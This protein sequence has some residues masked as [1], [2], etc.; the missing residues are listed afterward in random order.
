MKPPLPE[1]PAPRPIIEP[2]GLQKS[3]CLWCP[4]LPWSA[5]F[6]EHRPTFCRDGDKVL[7]KE[8]DGHVVRSRAV[9]EEWTEVDVL[10]VGEAP[11][12]DEDKQ[13]IPFVGRS[14]KLLRTGIEEVFDP[15]VTVGIANLVRC[16]PPRNR[17]PNRTEVQ[18]CS[19][20]LIRE[21]A[22]RKP[23]VIVVLGNHSMNFLTGHTGIT[24]FTGK[25]LEA[26]HPEVLGIPVVACLHPAYILRFDHELPKFLDAL[27][28]A[29]DVL[30]GN[31]E[32]KAGVG[33]VLVLDDLDDVRALL[34]AFQ[35]DGDRVAFDT[36]TG[37]LNWW[38]DEFPRLLCFSFANE[39]GTS[40]VVPFDHAESPWCVGG[41]K[42]HEREELIAVLAEFFTSDV[43]KL[44]QNGKFDSKH[45]RAAIGVLPVNVLDTMTT[46][47]TL[48]ERRG[49]HGLDA[50]AYQ[51]TG[52]G[53]YERA[54]SDY[55]NSHAEANPDRGGSYANIPG[56]I[57][58]KYA[59]WDA[60]ATLRVFHG[61]QAEDSYRKNPRFQRLAEMFFPALSEVLTELEW[62]GAQIDPKIV[63]ELDVSY[64][65]EMERISDEI[66]NLDT[67][68]AFV[69]KKELERF[70]PGSSKQLQEILFSPDFYGVAPIT[71]TKGGLDRLRLR[72]QRAVEAWRPAK[73]KKQPA[74]TDVVMEALKRGEYGH[75]STDA[76]AL[77]ELDL[78]GNELASK[79]VEYRAVATL[80]GTFIK[81][82]MLLLDPEGRI[83][84]SFLEHGTVT[85]RL[86]SVDPNLQNIPNKGEG[87]VK[88]AYVSRFGDE[89]VICQADYSQ[90]ELRIG[91][92]I[93]NEPSM[94]RAYCEGV[95]VHTLTAIEIAKLTP[96]AYKA[97]DKNEQKAWRTRAKR[98][99]FGILYQGG[100]AALVKTLK[101]DGVFITFEEA[102]KLIERY[103]EIRPA[104]RAGIDRLQNRV[105]KTGYLESF[106]G[107]R[108]R[109]P[110][111]ES[112]DEKLVSRALRQAVNFPVQSGA[113]DMTLMSLVLIHR[114][115][116]KRGLRSR[117]ILTVH[118]SIV[119]DCHVDE[120][121][122][123]MQLAKTIMETLP[124]RSDEVLPGIDWSWLKTPIVADCDVGTRWGTTIEFNPFECDIDDLWSKMAA[125]EAA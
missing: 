13:G 105:K 86:A 115:M 2:G 6:D 39:E 9:S 51:Y 100:P 90:I 33:E 38:Q 92:S 80:H 68:Q 48:D 20:E 72:H 23:K 78:G 103:Y 65:G 121:I 83:H 1:T 54:L 70:N 36:E 84:G 87:K 7:A 30:T 45:I 56:E 125:K 41:P 26:T 118:D 67:V 61:L 91:A 4:L 34:A 81:P 10:F 24:T 122:E 120:F 117:I 25:V 21:I 3:G 46:H 77:Q 69:A 66:T 124:Q 110:E 53:G 71:L 74:F 5:D 12:A 89:G 18:S 11:G 27:T 57:L 82:L 44:A 123:V 64:R 52:M 108:R 104:L 47:L 59:G 99:N 119:F 106:T 37:S 96:E 94:I 62:N 101:K 73:S 35:T 76:E 113:S 102:E 98:I 40:Y 42:E 50:L 107:R 85:G 116:R 8:P 109:V 15:K 43:P 29:R 95:D 75:F 55:V 14:G 16:R 32:Q 79:I 60:D 97:L 93:F 88:W 22:A 31:H 112:V 17:D 19:P 49:T 114:E 63:S 111:V 58:F 28:V